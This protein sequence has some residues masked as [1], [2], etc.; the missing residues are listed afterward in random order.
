MNSNIHFRAKYKGDFETDGE[1]FI[2]ARN[3][4]KGV[5]FNPEKRE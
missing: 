2:I 1:L 3:K 4:D 5:N